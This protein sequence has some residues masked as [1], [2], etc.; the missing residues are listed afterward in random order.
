MANSRKDL[1]VEFV[2]FCDYA[3]T[4]E[5]GKL[6]IVGMFETI[7]V[8]ELPASHPEMFLV[9]HLLGGENAEHNI[10]LKIID[11]RRKDLV[12]KDTPF[13]K[14]KLSPSGTGNLLHRMLNFPVESTGKYIFS[15]YEGPKKIAEAKLRVIQTKK[16]KDDLSN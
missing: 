10:K 3:Y 1:K 2:L 15:L 8:G 6:S 11:P 7:F 9:V 5:G 14:V 12:S 4:A 16:K 13:I